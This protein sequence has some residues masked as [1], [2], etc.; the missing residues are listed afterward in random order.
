MPFSGVGNSPFEQYNK[1]QIA[2]AFEI[3][4]EDKKGK[5]KTK[6]LGT[7]LAILG[8]VISNKDLEELIIKVEDNKTLGYMTL[9]KLQPVVLDILM[10]DKFKSST[11]EELVSAFRSI[12][13]ERRGYLDPDSLKNFLLEYGEP[14]D[15]E[16]E[17]FFEFAIDQKSKRIHYKD[18]CENLVAPHVFDIV[19]N[20][21]KLRKELSRE[22]V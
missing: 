2:A 14:L 16:I 9:D 4:D 22:H 7:I 10:K 5:A 19:E 17:H 1:E 11:R 8:R 18:I 6:N 12:D 15:D 13:R 3:F 21:S 20:R